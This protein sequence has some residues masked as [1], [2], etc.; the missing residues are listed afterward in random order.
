MKDL[1]LAF[2]NPECHILILRKTMPSLRQCIN[3][4]DSHNVTRILTGGNYS[5]ECIQDP[6]Q[7][8]YFQSD[9]WQIRDIHRRFGSRPLTTFPLTNILWYKIYLPYIETSKVYRPLDFVQYDKQQAVELLRTNMD[10]NPI[11]KNILSRGS[12]AMKHTGFLK[13]SDLIHEK[14][15]I[16]ALSLPV[17]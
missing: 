7:W 16:Q 13:S 14:S 11:N 12:P 1:Q 4:A 6:K 2:L 5:T 3:F 8:M 15:N 10:T 9:D 17:K